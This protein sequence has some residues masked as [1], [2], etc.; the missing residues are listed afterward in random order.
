MELLGAFFMSSD[1]LR[2]RVIAEWRGLPETA[3]RKDRCNLVGD[4][5]QKLLPRLGLNERLSEQ[6]VKEAWLEVVGS[7]LAQHSVPAALSGGVLTVQVLQPSVRYELERN[8][9]SEILQKL[10]ARFGKKVIR[11][12][13]FRIS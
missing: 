2:A 8:W 4:V 6:Q 13:K 5:L 7:F 10:Q 1:S 11:D 12:V 3:E 9:K